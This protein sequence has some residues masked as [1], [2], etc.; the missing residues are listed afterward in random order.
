MTKRPH[1]TTEQVLEQILSEGE[2][3]EDQDQAEDG[4]GDMDRDE[5]VMEGSDERFGRLRRCSRCV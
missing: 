4:R 1:W 2:P 5:P 3:T